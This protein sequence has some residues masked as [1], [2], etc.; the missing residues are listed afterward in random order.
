MATVVGVVVGLSWWVFLGL[1]RLDEL[2][3]FG[4]RVL[5]DGTVFQP[6][7]TSNLAITPW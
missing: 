6:Y 4:P 3:E 2:T 5:P 1:Y 7:M